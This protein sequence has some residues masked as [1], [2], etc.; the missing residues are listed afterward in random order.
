MLRRNENAV[1]GP[2][3]NFLDECK[4]ELV[5]GRYLQR[6]DDYGAEQV[7]SDSDKGLDQ[8]EADEHDTIVNDNQLRCECQFCHNMVLLND[9]DTH[10]TQCEQQLSSRQ[11]ENMLSL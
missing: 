7:H 8:P 4:Q 5:S 6:L 9:L 1:S 10:E 3:H 11:I 2:G